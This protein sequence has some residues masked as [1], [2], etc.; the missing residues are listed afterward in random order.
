MEFSF[1][2]V[3]LKQRAWDMLRG[4][5]LNALLIMFLTGLLSGIVSGLASRIIK[6]V[7]N[8][9]GFTI[10]VQGIDTD[11]IIKGV[12][13]SIDP[14]GISAFIVMYFVVFLMSLLTGYLLNTFA[15]E[16]ITVG[17]KKGYLELRNG[18]MNLDYMLCGFTANYKNVARA[19]AVKW[20][21][22]MIGN[23]FFV[24]PGIIFQYRYMMVPYILAENPDI[25]P[26]RALE[27]SRIMMKGNKLNTFIMQ[28]SF[29]G[30]FLLGSV[31]CCVGTMFV[32]PYY[33]TAE[34]ELYCELRDK[35]VECGAVSAAELSGIVIN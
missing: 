6:V 3:Q 21:Y 26:M 5:Y 25:D 24:I 17:Q 4:C 8:I 35:A 20:L 15:N 7:M 10:S 27:I 23:L 29:L 19:A 9:A 34:T 32:M 16:H 18:S 11:S 22:I 2:R 1:D 30:W 14:R 33:L 28:L 31:V 13:E 12:E